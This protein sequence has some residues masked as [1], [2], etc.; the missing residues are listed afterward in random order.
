[1]KI[2]LTLCILLFVV[3]CGWLIHNASKN[4]N[5]AANGPCIL[6]QQTTIS[7]TPE[8]SAPSPEPSAQEETTYDAIGGPAKIVTLGSSIIETGF[9]YELEL[10]STGAGI[11]R[12]TL[13][14]HYNRDR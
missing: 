4:S 3:L 9:K 12:A 1:M 14:E 10:S 11:R 7:P 6:L 5:T 2:I 8:T 13:S